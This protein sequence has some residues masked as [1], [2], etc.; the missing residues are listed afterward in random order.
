LEIS[1]VRRRDA[2][3]GEW[4]VVGHRRGEE[5]KE[6]GPD[7]EGFIYILGENPD[8]FWSEDRP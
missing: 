2:E 7:E 5:K 6:K 3:M 1:E 8:I 4:K